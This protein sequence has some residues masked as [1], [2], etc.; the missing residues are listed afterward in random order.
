MT[1]FECEVKEINPLT[2]FVN[3]VIL[4]PKT[5]ISFIAGQYIELVLS[6]NDKRPFSIA[7]TPLNKRLIE[8]QIGA[9]EQDNYTSAAMEHLRNNKTVTLKGPSGKAGLRYD[10][11]SPIILL[12]GERALV[13]LNPLLKHC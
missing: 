12:A 13:M 10:S 2:E 9:A 5:E 8:L 1:H 3:Q 6:E 11:H 4:Q 7:N